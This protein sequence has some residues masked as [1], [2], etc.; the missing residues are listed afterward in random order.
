MLSWSPNPYALA[1]IVSALVSGM[2]AFYGWSSRPR[3][4]AAAT[5]LMMLA[6]AEWSLGYAIAIGIHELAPRI[7]WAKVQHLG[8]PLVAPAMLIFALQYT[9]R[10]TWLTRRN[11]LLLMVLPVLDIA[12]SWTNEAHGLI[13]QEMTLVKVDSLSLLKLKY[14][15]FFWI[16]AFY[17][18]LLLVISSLLLGHAVLFSSGLRRR[19]SAVLLAGALM[20]W[21]AN[22]LYLT[23]VGPLTY[24]DLTPFG[25]SLTGLLLS[26]GL[27]RYRLF[28]AVPIAREKVVEHMRDAFIV[29][30]EQHRF[31]DLNPPALALLGV[32]PGQVLGKSALPFFGAWPELVE[33]FQTEAEGR[34]EIVL[35]HNGQPHH[36]A[37]QVS[38]L[39]NRHDR[40]IGRLLLLQDVSDRVRALSAEQAALHRE[41]H[42]ANSIQTGLLPQHG[43]RIP[44]L[45]IAG[46]SLPTNEVGGDLFN[47]YELPAESGLP[48]SYAIAIGDVSGKGVPAAL[49][50]AVT[51]IMLS[52]KAPFVP[53]VSQLLSEMNEA[54][55]PYMSPNRMNVALCYLRLVPDGFGQHTACIANAGMIAPLLWRAGRCEHLDIGGLPLGLVRHDTPYRALEMTLQA[56]D[57]L[58]LSSDGIVEAM[59]SSRELYGFDRLAERL[60]QRPSDDAQ[61]LLEWVLDDVRAF[62]GGAGQRDDLTLVVISVASGQSG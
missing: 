54:L 7:F 50:M 29:L 22:L 33:R 57:V 31:V 24:L 52:A 40:I 9:D 12:L 5:A 25:Y 18:Y 21:T 16:L 61:A 46:T 32:S 17:S 26:W 39:T 3:T 48:G 6:A 30:N 59:N 41:L 36:Y 4:G 38:Q 35:N 34:A 15:L 44:G 11:L 1:L 14:G 20:P 53:D 10:E 37:V 28:N 45:D 27:Y 55:Y 13:W 56:G 51:T 60:N 2:V 47:Y 49:Y 8:I 58:L 19:Q 62:I 23:R 42:M 43:P